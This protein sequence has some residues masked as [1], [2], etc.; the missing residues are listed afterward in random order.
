VNTWAYGV[1]L[2]VPRKRL[3]HLTSKE[4][5]REE[6]SLEAGVCLRTPKLGHL[7]IGAPISGRSKVPVLRFPDDGHEG[8]VVVRFE[9]RTADAAALLADLPHECG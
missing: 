4:I 5:E 7:H 3:E 9:M 6:A 8:E 2:R 1:E